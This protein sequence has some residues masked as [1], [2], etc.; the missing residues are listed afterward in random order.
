MEFLKKNWAKLIAATLTC[1]G[2]VLFIV[3]LCQYSASYH[4]TLT[5]PLLPEAMDDPRNATSFL[6]SHIA[7]LTFFT[8]ATAFIVTSMF[9]KHAKWI[10]CAIAILCTVFMSISICGAIGSENSKLARAVMNGEHD[11]T[12]TAAVQMEAS[13][14]VRTAMLAE[15]GTI[16]NINPALIPALSVQPVGNW[17]AILVGTGVPQAN[18]EAVVAGFNTTVTEAVTENAPIQIQE[19][20]DTARYQFF[21]RVVTLVTQLILFGLLPLTL[22]LKKILRKENN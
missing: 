7:G 22:G 12:I 16:Y 5:H 15:G 10:I 8:L 13:A 18:A 19:A 4:D 6:F 1:V 14:T 21:S 17:I 11:A 9:T 20:K 3:L 2:A